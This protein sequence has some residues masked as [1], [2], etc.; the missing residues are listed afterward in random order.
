MYKGIERRSDRP[1]HIY[2]AANKTYSRMRQTRGA[3]TIL[4]SGESGAGKTEST[5]L[6]IE[7]MAHICGDTRDKAPHTK[8]IKVNCMQEY[9][10][11]R[12]DFW[13]PTHSD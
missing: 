1:P 5:K 3:Q 10:S 7:H 4:M 12:E 9:V 8:L 11:S 6:V 2:W 13:N